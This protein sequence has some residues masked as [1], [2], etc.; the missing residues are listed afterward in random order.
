MLLVIDGNPRDDDDIV[1]DSSV[2]LINM[3]EQIRDVLHSLCW[4]DAVCSE[5]A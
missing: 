4:G 1:A 2:K 3:G 5:F